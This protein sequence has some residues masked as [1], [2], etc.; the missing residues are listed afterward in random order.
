[1]AQKSS[2]S[3]TSDGLCSARPAGVSDAAESVV[4][5]RRCSMKRILLSALVAGLIGSVATM[6]VVADPQRPADEPK[7]GQREA[8]TG[9]ELQPGKDRPKPAANVPVRKKAR[10][11]L[12][13]ET[14]PGFKCAIEAVFDPRVYPYK[15][16]GGTIT[17]SFGG[18]WRIREGTFGP[19][20]LIKA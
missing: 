9:R 19:K 2:S 15:I 17:G 4:P 16:L 20:L 18:P 6:V 1:T 3:L 12:Y 14:S 13:H 8:R 5:R 10:F 7:R 11:E